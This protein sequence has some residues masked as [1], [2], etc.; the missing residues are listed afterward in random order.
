M[1]V[2]PYVPPPCSHAWRQ[3][4]GFDLCGH[5]HRDFVILA[6]AQ[7]AYEAPCVQAEWP[8][9]RP[10]ALYGWPKE[11]QLTFAV[12]VPASA[13]ATRLRAHLTTAMA[14]MI[15]RRRILLA[16]L[17]RAAKTFFAPARMLSRFLAVPSHEVAAFRKCFHRRREG[18]DC[19][20]GDRTNSGNGG[21]SRQYPLC[22]N[23]NAPQH[24][25]PGS[26]LVVGAP[27]RAL[28]QVVCPR[29][30]TVA[31]IPSGIHLVNPG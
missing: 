8:T 4:G 15:S 13:R 9:P 3:V 10:C 12:C 7:R 14:P 11:L 22:L 6:V 31:Q 20:C 25:S 18:C 21:S 17:R 24:L 26:G 28:W 19:R 23:A 1:T 27:C 5:S 30:G 29:H 2:C 16:H